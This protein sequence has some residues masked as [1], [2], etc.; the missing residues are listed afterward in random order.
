MNEGMQNKNGQKKRQSCIILEKPI[1]RPSSS[2]DAA[3]EKIKWL[4]LRLMQYSGNKFATSK[5]R[6]MFLR[7]RF[8]IHLRNLTAV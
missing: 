5:D 1:C 3:G 2:R 4:G 8:L 6:E 7:D